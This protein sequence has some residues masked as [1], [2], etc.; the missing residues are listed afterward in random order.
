[1]LNEI[2]SNSEIV[3]FDCYECYVKGTM[4]SDVLERMAR[5]RMFT[6]R[7]CGNKRCP[8]GTNHNLNCTNSNEPG[9]KG[10]RYSDDYNDVEN[11][12]HA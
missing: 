8:K 1:M 12:L 6:C 7:I 11:S 2:N 5:M 10:S 9:Q 4:N 3:E